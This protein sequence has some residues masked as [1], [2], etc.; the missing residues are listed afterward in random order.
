VGVAVVGRLFVAD[1]VLCFHHGAAVFVRAGARRGPSVPKLLVGFRWRL[2]LSQ[3]LL[4]LVLLVFNVAST[5]VFFSV[6]FCVVPLLIPLLFMH[7]ILEYVDHVTLDSS[8]SSSD[9]AAVEKL[10]WES[11]LFYQMVR[12]LFATS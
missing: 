1:P 8:A 9:W 10:E 7:F 3:V 6:D 4:L 2:P 5:F 12:S 11:V